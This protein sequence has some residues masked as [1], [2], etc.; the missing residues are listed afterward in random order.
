[1]SDPLY[2]GAKSRAVVP[3]LGCA[4]T[5]SAENR[6]AGARPPESGHLASA[7]AQPGS[8]RVRWR[9]DTFFGM[10]SLKGYSAPRSPEGRSSLVP[11]PPWHYVGDMLVVEFWADAAAAAAVLPEPLEPHPDG[12]RAAAMFLDWQSCSDGGGEL[13]DPVRSQYREFFITVNATYD[14]RG[15]RVL[16]LHLGRPR[17]RARTRLDPGL[18]EEARLRVDHA[19][20]R[21][22]HHRG[23][24][25]ARRVDGSPA[26]A[27]RTTA[28]SR[29]RP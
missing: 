10:G 8:G 16:P 4:Q 18:S 28:G 15:G 21:A 6:K 14:G 17:L 25:P 9:L 26:P 5:L 29:T 1:M 2:L 3:S 24:G 20:V 13:L 27:R 7:V 12:G 11:A 19:D 22:R 23:P